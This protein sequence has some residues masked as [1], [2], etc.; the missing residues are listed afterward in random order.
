MEWGRAKSVLIFAFLVLNIVLGYQLWSNIQEG[1]SSSGDV[2]DLSAG[3]LA[4]MRDKGIKL[5][6]RSIPTETP[7]LRELTYRVTEKLGEGKRHTLQVPVDSKIVFNEKELQNELGSVIPDLKEYTYDPALNED[8][9]F[10]LHR[11]AQDRPMFDIRLK[12]YFSN[13]KIVAYSQDRVE[14]ITGDE[15]AEQTVLP[16]TKALESLIYNHFKPGAV[17]KDIKLGYHGQD[18]N[19][20]TQFSAP[21]WRVLLEDGLVYYVHAIS[22]EVFTEKE[23]APHNGDSTE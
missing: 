20:D 8:E 6:A 13:Q 16:A 2:K 23:E 4:V 11:E 9:A 19:S 17:I 10:I 3:T 18:F 12:L 22:A 7:K 5:D 1:P 15:A 21:S 14:L